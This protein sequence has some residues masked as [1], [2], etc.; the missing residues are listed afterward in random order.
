MDIY[1]CLFKNILVSSKANIYKKYLFKNYILKYFKLK[2]VKIIF[3]SNKNV[4]IW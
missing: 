4:L 3:N 1:V 2:I